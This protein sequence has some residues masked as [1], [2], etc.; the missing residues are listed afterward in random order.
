MF[1]YAST[2]E[3]GE[4]L[5]I[6]DGTAVGTSM[7]LDIHIGSTGSNPRDLIWYKSTLFFRANDGVFGHELWISDGTAEGTR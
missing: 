7:V 1:F 5:W 2:S 6:S 3:T 4:E